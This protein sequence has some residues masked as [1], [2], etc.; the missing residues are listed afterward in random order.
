MIKIPGHPNLKVFVTQ[1]GIQSIDEALS[2]HVPL[3]VMPKMGDQRFNARRAVNKGMGL[4]V[5]FETVTKEDLKA[6][7]FEVV[8]NP[9]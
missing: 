8:N 7:V 6:A 1:G 5:D 2:T 3:V 9:K 4:R